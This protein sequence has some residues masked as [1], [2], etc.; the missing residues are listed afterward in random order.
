MGNKTSKRI[1]VLKKDDDEEKVYTE[2]SPEDLKNLLSSEEGKEIFD[3]DF[4]EL[5]IEKSICSNM[6]SLW[7]L[8]KYK[9][10]YKLFIAMRAK[11]SMTSK[12]SFEIIINEMRCMKKLGNSFPNVIGYVGSTFSSPR[13]GF[14]VDFHP[15]GNI[16]ELLKKEEE[17]AF[18]TE[19][20]VKILVQICE[21]LTLIQEQEICFIIWT[22]NNFG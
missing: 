7:Y 11:D 8:V 12:E 6:F 4:D 1:P 19:Q 2:L 20:K 14:V 16:R 9:E 21:C 3:V 15:K 13:W 5:S 22:G 17:S 10:E 18:S